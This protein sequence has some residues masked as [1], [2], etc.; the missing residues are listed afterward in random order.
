MDLVSFI[1]IDGARS[2]R[3][4]PGV[5]E[6]QGIFQRSTFEKVE[7]YVILESAGS[8]DIPFL[9]PNRSISLPFYSP[10]TLHRCIEEWRDEVSQCWKREDVVVRHAWQNGEPRRRH[11]ADHRPTMCRT[12]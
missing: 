10:F 6:T 3:I 9:R 12:P 8:N 7:L 1:E 5:E 2:L 4:Q 11:P